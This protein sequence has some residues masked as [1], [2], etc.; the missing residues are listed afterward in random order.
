MKLHT[1]K[2]C[3]ILQKMTNIQ[4]KSYFKYSYEIC[5]HHHERYDG[6]GYPDGLVGDQI[7]LEAQIVSVADVFDALTSVRCYKPA[8]SCEKALQMIIDGECGV[9]SDKILQSLNEVKESFFVYVNKS[10]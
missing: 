3:D 2:G 7:P 4:E 10:K 5:R 9:F 1:V 6:K 8:Y